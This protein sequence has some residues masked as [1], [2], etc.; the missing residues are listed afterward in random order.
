MTRERCNQDQGEV[1]SK[2]FYVEQRSNAIIIILNQ[3]SNKLST[4]AW[5]SSLE[6]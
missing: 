6:L 4:P 5:T 1:F 2:Q 3:T